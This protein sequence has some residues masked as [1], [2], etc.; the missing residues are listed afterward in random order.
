MS[1]PLAPRKVI[2]M[3]YANRSTTVGCVAAVFLPALFSTT[4]SA[5]GVADADYRVEHNFRY[6]PGGD[7]VE[8]TGADF[9]HAWIRTSGVLGNA[10]GVQSINQNFNFD[11]FGTESFAGGAS[12]FPIA[13]NSGIGGTPVECVYNT[14]II[15]P[16]GINQFQCI[17]LPHGISNAAACTEY[18]VFPYST[19]APFD[20]QGSVASSGGVH[21]FNA[22]CYA[23]SSAAISV[24]GGIDMG[25]GVIQWNPIIHEIVGGGVGALGTMQDPVHIIA[26]N[27]DTGDVIDAPLLNFEIVADS[28]GTLDWD[29]GVFETDHQDLDFR[30]EIPAIHVA[31]GES[32]SIH[33]RVESGIITIADDTGIFDNM[34]PIAGTSVPFTVP[35]P[36]DFVLNYNLN[37]DPAFNWEV[38]ADLS[39]GGGTRAVAQ[40]APDLTGDGILDIFDV[41]LFL[42]F[43]NEG[44]PIA[45]FTGDEVFDIFDVFAFLDAFNSGCGIDVG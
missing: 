28:T 39:G 43:F 18:F 31:P 1:L 3:R 23:Y 17:V 4:A 20:I 16:A 42:D 40:C 7:V 41:F 25:N 8:V 45:D 27:L 34:L 10:W 22:E 29:A 44:N 24:R 21:A 11:P 13:F 38:F 5:Q 6:Q 37:L 12:G 32:G 33:L 19:T 9:R 26:Q 15:P 2:S 14:F 30:F 36:N 35:M